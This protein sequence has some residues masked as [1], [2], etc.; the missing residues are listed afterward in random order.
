MYCLGEEFLARSTACS[1]AN[2]FDIVCRLDRDGK[3][4]EGPQNK[5]H[6]VATGLLRDKLYE[7]DFAGPISVRASKVLGP[8]S[9]YRVADILHRMKLVSRA[10]RPGL[11]VGVLRILCNGLC[12]SQ[13]FTLKSMIIRAVLDVPMNP[14]LSLPLQRVSSHVQ[15]VHLYLATRCCASTEKPSI[16]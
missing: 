9:L 11:T 7:Q 4:D 1:T 6:E 15:Y 12:T 2:A 3:L 8:I 5:K 14:A 13:D 16:P 10:S